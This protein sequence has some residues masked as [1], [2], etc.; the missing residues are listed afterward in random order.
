MML[1]THYILNC[2]DAEYVGSMIQIQNDELFPFQLLS[3]SNCEYVLIRNPAS[4]LSFYSVF[5]ESII[6]K[7]IIN[8]HSI[9]SLY[10]SNTSQQITISDQGCLVWLTELEHTF[11]VCS[12]K[13]NNFFLSTCTIASA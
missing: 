13:H 2:Y 8:N 4:I 6:H 1:N 7:W 3:S 9:W 11:G 12:N 5:A 10:P